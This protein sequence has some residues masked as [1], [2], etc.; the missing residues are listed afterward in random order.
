MTLSLFSTRLGQGNLP[1]SCAPAAAI[2]D[3]AILQPANW[4]PHPHSSHP[5]SWL[6]QV[7]IPS[8][9]NIHS[10]SVLHSVF[11]VY[12]PY[13]SINPYCLVMFAPTHL[14]ACI[15]CM[16]RLHEQMVKMNQSLHRLQVTWQEAQRT[17]SQMSE[18]LLEQ[19][20]RLMI[21][22]LSTKAA[23]TQPTMLQCCLNLQ[24][25]T[26]ALLVQLAVGNQGPEHVA[27]SFPLPSLRNTMLCYIPGRLTLH[28]S[29]FTSIL[30]LK[31]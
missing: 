2:G 26:A 3:C 10:V 4:K 29:L 13:A 20:E 12:V 9:I 14:Y 30:D 16:C 5:A 25:S 7:H 19:F 22:Y 11:I 27:L 1:N 17:G 18:Q 24:S 28:W 23:T 31:H 15:M 6:P 8:N 21:I